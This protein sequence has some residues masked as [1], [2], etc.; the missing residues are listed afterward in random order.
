MK[1][2]HAWTGKT[3]EKLSPSVSTVYWDVNVF[4]T[5]DEQH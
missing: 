4:S 5:A 1:N 3:G 2:Y